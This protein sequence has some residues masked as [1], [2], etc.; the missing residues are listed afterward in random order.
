MLKPRMPFGR[1]LRCIVV[2]LRKINP[3]VTT[4]SRGCQQGVLQVCWET[5]LG[6]RLRGSGSQSTGYR[7]WP[8]GLVSC[9]MDTA[10]ADVLVGTDEGA[11]FGVTNVLHLMPPLLYARS[12][13]IS[14]VPSKGHHDGVGGRDWC[15][16]IFG[17][18]LRIRMSATSSPPAMRRVP[19]LSTGSAL[20]I[21]KNAAGDTH[22]ST[23]I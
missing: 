15:L 5:H 8:N 1:D 9:A 16:Y 2:M 18:A 12:A 11:S 23:P 6:L 4:W 14:D 10:G 20:E 19:D 21:A 17:Q 13:D 22:S 3:S 7:T